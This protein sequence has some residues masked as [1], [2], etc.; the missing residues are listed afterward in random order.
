MALTPAVASGA[1]VDQRTPWLIVAGLTVAIVAA[2]GNTLQAVASRW[3]EDQYSHGF[4]VPIFAAVLIAMLRQ[5]FR[6][7]STSERWWGIAIIG[8]GLL[9]RLFAAYFQAA[10]L[11][12]VSFIPTLSGVFVVAG[13]WSALRWSWAPV[14]FLV[15]MIPLPGVMEQHFLMPLQRIA[16][17]VSTFCLQTIGVDAF[18][19]GSQIITGGNFKLNVAEQCSGLRMA[20]IF[21]ALSVAMSLIIDRPW[22]TKAVI[23]ISGIPVAI[24][25]N[26]IRI[27]MTAELFRILGQDSE[28]AKH[29]FHDLAGWFMMPIALAIMYVELLIMDHLFVEEEKRPAPVTGFGPA[30]VIRRPTPTQLR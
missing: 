14:A 6:Q 13:G 5:P 18:N 8:G 19:N 4:L 9:V 11:N 21:L 10:T 17:V 3:S 28:L 1:E 26:V 20:T 22:W 7:V 30:P 15:F 16:T 12:A 24:A 29:F 23:I 2:Y 27:V 25:V